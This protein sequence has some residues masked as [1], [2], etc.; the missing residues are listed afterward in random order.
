VDYIQP[1]ESAVSSFDVELTY[2]ILDW[3]IGETIITN[4]SFDINDVEMEQRVQLGFNIWPGGQSLLHML[5]MQ[6][7]IGDNSLITGD[8]IAAIRTVDG[9]YEVCEEFDVSNLS[10]SQKKV[11]GTFNMGTALRV[12]TQ[13]ELPLLPNMYGYTAL[14]YCLPGSVPD[15]HIDE[16]VFIEDPA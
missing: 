14:D 16:E 1:W 13:L 5:S 8:V 6:G 4:K 15:H 2:T 12:I 9:L 3:K 10:H 11:V 7:I